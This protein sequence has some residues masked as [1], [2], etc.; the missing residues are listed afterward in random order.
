MTIFTYC[1][2]AAI[3]WRVPFVVISDLRRNTLFK[4]LAQEYG[5]SSNVFH[6]Q[7]TRMLS[8]EEGLL[9]RKLE[10]NLNQRDI[11]IEDFYIN[12]NLLI[13][14][15]AIPWCGRYVL[16]NLRLFQNTKITVNRLKIPVSPAPHEKTWDG[17]VREQTLRKVIDNVKEPIDTH[18]RI[19][20]D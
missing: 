7:V 17:F 15:I 5:L 13:K 2:L 6:Y 10:G 12:K 20:T 14:A 11:S 8:A 19:T 4:E 9:L 18:G 3:F 16:G 1:L